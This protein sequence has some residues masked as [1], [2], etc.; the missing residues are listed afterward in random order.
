MP[1][2]TTRRRYT[3]E[4]G[5]EAVTGDLSIEDVETFLEDHGERNPEL[6]SVT[7]AIDDSVRDSGTTN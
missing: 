7:F 4:P 3:L 1:G 6:V 5:H 2:Q